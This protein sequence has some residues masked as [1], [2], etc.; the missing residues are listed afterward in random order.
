M[1]QLQVCSARCAAV[2]QCSVRP[3]PRPQKGE[4]LWEYAHGHDSRP[5]ES[6]KGRKSGERDCVWVGGC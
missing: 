1:A 2:T 3:L 6:I 4:Q 5:V